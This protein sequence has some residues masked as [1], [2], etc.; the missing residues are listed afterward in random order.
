MDLNTNL[1]PDG[2]AKA[3]T[4]P[5]SGISS[6]QVGKACG[7]NPPAIW[8][9]VVDALRAFG[10]DSLNVQIAAAA[11]CAVECNFKP[12][13]ERLSDPKRQPKVFKAQSRYWPWFGRGLIQLTWEANYRRAGAALHI[14]LISH[15]ELALEPKTAARILAWFFVE[16]QV[17]DAAEARDWKL[18]RKRVN[19]GLNGWDRFYDVVLR[20]LEEV[21]G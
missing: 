12:I 13:C 3:G 21:E 18:V 19:G 15:P 2:Q 4:N 10:I 9:L 11:T 20:L 16:N 7:I 8:P 6:E 14:D 1:S 5:A 17:D